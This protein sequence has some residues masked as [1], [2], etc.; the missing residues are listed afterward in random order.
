[1]ATRTRM[2]F[3]KI[4]EYINNITL[5]ILCSARLWLYKDLT[6]H[7]AAQYVAW[8]SLPI[9]LVLFSAGFV[10]LMAPQAIGKYNYLT[11]VIIK[12]QKSENPIIVMNSEVLNIFG[13]TNM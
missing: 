2:T 10:Q 8:I 7:P 5:N 3:A 6:E 13:M 1:M 12:K 9:C 4:C 11:N